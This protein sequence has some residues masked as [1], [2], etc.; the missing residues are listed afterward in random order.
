MHPVLVTTY[1]IQFCPTPQRQERLNVGLVA[2]GS[3]SNELRFDFDPDAGKRAAAMWPL[4]WVTD[5]VKGQCAALASRLQEARSAASTAA[6]LTD[7]V[8]AAL[9]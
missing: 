6:A 3:A 7:E 5:S 1:L 9:A 8:L 4:P 2:I